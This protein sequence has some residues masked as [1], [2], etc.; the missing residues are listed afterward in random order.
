MSTGGA[1]GSRPRRSQAQPLTSTQR[2][3]RVSQP[4]PPP[5]RPE[6]EIVDAVGEE[7][8]DIVR[9]RSED[10]NESP[11]PERDTDAS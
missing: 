6:D 3:R 2:A 5:W 11:S 8:I 7:M 1:E 10:P 9:E 4:R